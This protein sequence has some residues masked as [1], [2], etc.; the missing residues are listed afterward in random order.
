MVCAACEWPALGYTASMDYSKLK[1]LEP[2]RLRGQELD[3]ERVVTA[4]VKVKEANYHPRLLAVRSQIDNCLFTA[5]FKAK[6]LKDL[7][8]DPLVEA[9]SLAQ[10]LPSW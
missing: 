9:I 3:A 5:E 8:S 10:A 2:N 4:I 7:E 6:N 1:K